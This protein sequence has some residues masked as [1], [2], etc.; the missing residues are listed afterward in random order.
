MKLSKGKLNTKYT[1]TEM[2]FCEPCDLTKDSCDIIKLMER[3][4]V[5]GQELTII[6]RLG[7]LTHIHL[8]GEG[9]YIL[10]DTNMDGI[11]I[12]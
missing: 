5:V 3:G 8:E 12:E 11:E 7:N 2:E 4:F 9:D 10:R 6:K 1:I